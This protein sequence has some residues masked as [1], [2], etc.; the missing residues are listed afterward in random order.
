MTDETHGMADDLMGI[1]DRIGDR[2][3]CKGG[4]PLAPPMVIA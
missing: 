3:T 2:S 1:S 4:V